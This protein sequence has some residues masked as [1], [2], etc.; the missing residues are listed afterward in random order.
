MMFEMNV[1]V[2]IVLQKNCLLLAGRSQESQLLVCIM[3]AVNIKKIIEL[4]SFGRTGTKVYAR[5][6]WMMTLQGELLL[7]TLHS[8]YFCSK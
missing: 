5:T 8:S 2:F 1:Y 6:F 4:I 7:L 3:Y